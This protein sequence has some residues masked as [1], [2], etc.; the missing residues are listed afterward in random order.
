MPASSRFPGEIGAI[1]YDGGTTFRVWAPNAPSVNVGGGF[2]A[3]SKTAAPLAAEG[4]GCWSADVPGVKARDEYKFFLGGGVGWRLDPCAKVVTSTVGNA[5]VYDP[6]FP[7]KNDFAM[8]PRGELVV[9]E[10]HVGTFPDHPQAAADLLDAVIAD[11]G[12][13]RD[14]GVNAIELL[15]QGEFPGDVSWGYNPSLIDAVEHIYGGPDALKRLVDAAHGQGIAVILD[16]V[17][18]HLGPTD[19]SVWQFDGWF[20]TSNG[21]DMGGIYFYNDWR[22]DTPWGHKNRPGYGRPEV[23]KYI[24]D[25]ALQWLEEF[26]FD[27]LRFDST[28]FIRNVH[29][30]DGAPLDDPS[31]LGGAGWDLLKWINDEVN[32]RQPWKITIAEDLQNNPWLTTPTSIGGAG[33]GAQWDAGF[34]HPLR[35]VLVAMDDSSR[36][37][38]AVR[39]VIE[40]RYHNAFDR[41]IY[42]ESHDEVAASNGKR[43]LPDDVFPGQADGWFA[44]KRSTLG[45]A[46]VFTAPGIPMI[47]QGQE[48]LESRPFGDDRMDWDNYDRFRGIWTLYRDLIHLRRNWF[49]TTRGLRG[50]NVNIFHVNDADK[51]IAFHRWQAGGARDD[52]VV[53]LNFADRTY[54][55]YSI[56][57]PRGGLWKVR[58]N[59]DWNGYSRDYGNAA[60]DDAFGDGPVLHGLPV[61][62]RVGL[63]P[64]SA[65]VLSQDD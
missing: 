33:F 55:G 19:L 6:S 41:V 63:G 57:L 17:Y 8:P 47:C 58:F 5:L 46:L 7:W 61:S 62:A 35:A 11:L 4:N 43:R 38:N 42:T 52:V 36:D 59:S 60:S 40:H 51:V 16:V 45:A 28:I 27:G 13:L 49:D 1:A 31:N 3:W 30:D 23:R 29:G 9:Y 15:P 56:G 64:Y 53:V 18:N 10:L 22:A 39:G 2:N 65:V 50:P 48:I 44:R 25:S 14:L 37:M 54:S 21:D 20:Q 12:Y 32:D 26:R 34:H 24:R